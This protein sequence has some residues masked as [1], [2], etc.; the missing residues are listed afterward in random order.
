M[1]HR[2]LDAPVAFPASGAARGW[3]AY[4]APKASM[5]IA[6]RGTPWLVKY[7]AALSARARESV[8]TS[9]SSGVAAPLR[10]TCLS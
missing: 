10:I 5:M 3:R 4:E 1:R 9:L 6:L 7:A 8:A 2:Q